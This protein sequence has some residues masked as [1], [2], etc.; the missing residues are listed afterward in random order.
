M[1]AAQKDGGRAGINPIE[2]DLPEE[3]VKELRGELLQQADINK[4]KN[5]LQEFGI[6]V[7]N[8][9]IEAVKRY[10]FDSPGIAFARQNY[11]AW[12]NLATG[13]GTVND[14]RFLVHEMTE[15][16]ELQRIQQ[17]T[18]FD[19]MGSNLENMGRQQRRQW[20]VNF[21]LYYME[22]HSKALE[23]EY[24]FIA[25]QVAS[26]T[27]GRVN[28]SRTVA[29]AVDPTRDEA[30]LYMLVDGVPLSEHRN[31]Q[32]WQQRAKEIVE[33]GKGTKERLG[34]SQNPTLAD[35]IAAVKRQKLR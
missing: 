19:F 25:Q 24:D 6:P 18:G 12:K 9:M 10:T 35:L 3:R 33:I 5:A 26:A 4:V 34:L 11:N 1:S 8:Q 17:Q 31:F 30:R 32:R 27:N 14:A 22:A 21:E 16:K 23:S 13:K 15:I 28:I 7:D 2:W 29:A 20:G